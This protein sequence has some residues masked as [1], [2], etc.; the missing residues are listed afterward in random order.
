MRVFNINKTQNQTE[1][2]VLILILLLFINISDG[3]KNMSKSKRKNKPAKNG[4]FYKH[5]SRIHEQGKGEIKRFLTN[6][7]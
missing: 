1:K 2:N 6:L 4:F 5:I 3:D 7:I